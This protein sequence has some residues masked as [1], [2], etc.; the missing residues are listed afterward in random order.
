MRMSKRIVVLALT[1]TF[2]SVGLASAAVPSEA[3]ANHPQVEGDPGSD[4]TAV[5]PTNKQNEPTVAVNPIDSRYLIAGSNDE[6]RQPPCGSGPVRGTTLDSDCSFFPGVGTAGVYTSGDG[7]ASWTNRGLLDD[8]A[9]WAGKGVI[10]DGDPVIAF[11]PKPAPGGGF[12]WANG[13]RAYYSTLATIP[14][15]KGFEFIIVSTSDD[16]GVTWS[17]PVIGTTKI[18]FSRLQ[19]Q[20]LD[21]CRHVTG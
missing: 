14:S 13:A 19:R 18:Q 10:S 5:F 17:A 15:Q 16:N 6:Q 11:G 4:A 20:K 8:Q 1:C 2:A 3:Q 7:G 9:S 21:R 12:S